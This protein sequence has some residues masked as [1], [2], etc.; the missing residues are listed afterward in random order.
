MSQNAAD[1]AF[2]YI[3]HWANPEAPSDKGQLQLTVRVDG[4]V[5]ER[6]EGLENYLKKNDCVISR[7]DVLRAIIDVGLEVFKDQALAVFPLNL[8]EDEAIDLHIKNQENLER[9]EET[10]IDRE[11]FRQEQEEHADLKAKV[12]KAVKGGKK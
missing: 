11:V 7:A 10:A 1:E 5:A 9:Q 6:L 8:S 4:L 3:R 12:V 2:S